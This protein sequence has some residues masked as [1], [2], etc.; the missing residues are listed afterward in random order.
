LDLSATWD[1]VGKNLLI[2]RPPGQVV[3]KI[4][5]V[6]PP[7]SKAPEALAVTWKPDG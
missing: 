2:Y 3:S 5:Q 7:G 6:A 4:H 1:A